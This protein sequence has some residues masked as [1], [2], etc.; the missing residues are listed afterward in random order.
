MKLTGFKHKSMADMDADERLIYGQQLIEASR[1]EQEA[2]EYLE[3]YSQCL[4]A[5]VAASSRKT[6]D[7]R[8]AYGGNIVCLGDV[9]E[10][11]CLKAME[12]E[13]LGVLCWKHVPG[14]GLA[15]YLD[16]SFQ[17]NPE[18]KNFKVTSELSFILGRK[19]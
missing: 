5:S 4:A 15:P 14:H 10:L 16:R 1:K 12:H 11:E 17:W 2:Q 19:R 9:T 6:A 13:G 7:E 18:V 8:V 3:E